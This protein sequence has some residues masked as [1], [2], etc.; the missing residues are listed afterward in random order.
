MA[1][2]PAAERFGK[3][4][5][6]SHD[7]KPASQGIKLVAVL[8]VAAV[9]R[10]SLFATQPGLI[11]TLQDRIELNDPSTSWK[12]MLK[13]HQTLAYPKQQVI[14]SIYDGA[15][16]DDLQQGSIGDVGTAAA[17][18]QRATA[19]PLLLSIVG[20]FLVADGST[21]GVSLGT[22]F[23]FTAMDLISAFSIFQIASLRLRSPIAADVATSRQIGRRL[24]ARRLFNIVHGLR[25]SPSPVWASAVFVLNPLTT[26]TCLSLGG[27]VITTPLT[28]LSTWAAMAGRPIVAAVGISLAGAISFHPLLLLPAIWILGVNQA[29]FWRHNTG[30]RIGKRKSDSIFD[31]IKPIVASAASLGLL[32]G[33][34][35][36]FI[37]DANGYVRG[38]NYDWRGLLELYQGL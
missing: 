19:T 17:V 35:A 24:S 28:L 25:Q 15:G 38:G 21:Q 4:M 29:R 27:G 34:S 6:S 11:A 32:A 37:A 31:W 14:S 23:F 10:L 1:G 36:A 33:F 18:T 26:M 20:P 5:S 16:H 9:V 2:H 12:T 30:R 3:A 7:R 13:A 22:S 8:I